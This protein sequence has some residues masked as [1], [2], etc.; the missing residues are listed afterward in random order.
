MKKGELRRD[1]IMRTAEKLFFEKG[2]AETSIQDILDALEISKGGFYHYFES[3]NA[4][5]EEICRQ[6]SAR[7]IERMRA[8]LHAGKS[9]AVRKLNL[10]LGALNLFSR[11]EPKYAALVLKVSYI[12]GDVH[13]RDQL[14]TFML[15]RLRPMLDDASQEGISEGSLFSRRPG[16]LGAILLMLGYDVNDEACRI[17][18]AEPENPECAIQI[19]DILDAYREA[20]EALSGAPFGSVSLFDLEQMMESFRQTAGELNLLKE[21]V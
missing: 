20:V 13:F 19:M 12:D 4:L 16:V 10:I 17:L 18:A 2:F 7:D 9:D 8:A 11:E 15:E 5:L 3:K 1:A 14:R 21:K 6:R